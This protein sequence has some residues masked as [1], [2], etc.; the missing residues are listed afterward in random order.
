MWKQIGTDPEQKLLNTQTAQKLKITVDLPDELQ[1]PSGKVRT[2]YV[3]RVHNGQATVLPTVLNGNE[4]SFETDMF[5]TYSV[6][7]TENAASAPSDNGGGTSGGSGNNDNSGSNDNSGNTNDQNT[8]SEQNTADS[9]NNAA[10][11]PKTGDESN[12]V[13]WS[14]LL[15]V[16][17][18][19]LAEVTAK[20]KRG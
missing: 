3:I 18:V 7:Y 15:L 19:A 6:W 1:A 14:M 13:L 16:S 10:Y 8:S 12:M 4:I 20:R 11:V 17:V 5:S 2:Y 9:N